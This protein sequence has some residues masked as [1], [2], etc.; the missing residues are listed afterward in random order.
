[1]LP[2]AVT[3][4]RPREHDSPADAWRV[5]VAERPRLL[6]E[7]EA[8]HTRRSVA[9]QA[10]NESAFGAGDLCGRHLAVRTRPRSVRV[11]SSGR[12]RLSG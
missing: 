8:R 9:D 4:P 7:Q 5:G 6:A 2:H 11:Q 12:A 1:M 10:G 3:R